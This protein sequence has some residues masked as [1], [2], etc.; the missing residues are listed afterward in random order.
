MVSLLLAGGL[1]LLV[2]LFGTP[3]FVKFLKRKSYGQ[4][5]REDGP[6]SH[7]TKRGTPTMGGV[8]IMLGT[9]MGYLVANL[10]AQRLPSASGYLLLFLMF[11]L[12]FVGFCDD[13]TKVK[14]ERSLGLTP[15]AKILGQ[16]F[17]GIVFA[18]LV[19]LFKDELNRTPA[20]MA[21]SFVRDT[22]ISLT[23]AGVAVGVILFIIWA[24]FLITA[25]S[26]AVNLTD[27]LD[28]LA[29]GA[30]AIA[31]GAYTI[32]MLWQGYQRCAAGIAAT[33]GCY[34]VRDPRDLAII[35]AAIMGSCVGFL[36]HNTSPARIFMG[37]T[38]SL[39]LGGAFAGI[40]ILSQTEFLALFFGGLFLL[41]MISDVIQIVVFKRTRRRVFRMAPIHHHFELKGWKEVTIVVRFWLIQ[42]MLAALGVSI[43]YGEWWAWQ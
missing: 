36:W 26:N 43:F 15:A 30:S 10:Y 4:F 1:S 13:F 35:A 34:D 21:I 6:T 3:L 7:L 17:V 29:A 20:S 5:I 41:E 42:I 25:W 22:R 40:S 23:F 16:G 19:L 12:G 31:F 33:P 2:T 39:A 8:V 37:D 32:V 11:G 18:A 24:N 38:G 9:L 28:G 27:G 14:K